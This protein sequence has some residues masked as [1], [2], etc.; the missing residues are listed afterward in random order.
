MSFTI[1]ET[2]DKVLKRMKRNP[3]NGMKL[4]M[5]MGSNNRN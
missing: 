2:E 5:K 4:V 1:K 3:L